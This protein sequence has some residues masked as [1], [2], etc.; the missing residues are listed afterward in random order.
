MLYVVEQRWYMSS[1]GGHA[2]PPRVFSSRVMS[3]A[4]AIEGIRKRR[5]AAADSGA[6]HADYW[7]RPVEELA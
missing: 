1:V 6:G 7:L 3:Y 2:F 4:D 5:Y